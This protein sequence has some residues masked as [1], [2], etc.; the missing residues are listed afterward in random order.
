MMADKEVQHFNL[1]HQPYKVVEGPLAAAPAS[2]SATPTPPP[3]PAPA[4]TAP[5][6]DTNSQVAG[7]SSEPL[8]QAGSDGGSDQPRAARAVSADGGDG[9]KSDAPARRSTRAAAA[10]AAAAS[11]PPE[12]PPQERTPPTV[13]ADAPPPP[14]QAP[15]NMSNVGRKDREA[16]RALLGFTQLAAGVSQWRQLSPHCCETLQFELPAA[17][18]CALIA[19]LTCTLLPLGT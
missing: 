9:A 3:V 10:A 18:R 4:A 16:A 1:Q 14:R 11:R 17:G 15:L 13:S 2:K 12:P 5:A 7:R 19:C 8:A 6:K